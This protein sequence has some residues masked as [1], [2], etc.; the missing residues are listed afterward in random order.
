MVGHGLHE[1]CM[2]TSVCFIG[3]KDGFNQT[4]RCSQNFKPSN[5]LGF[6]FKS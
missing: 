5:E 3:Q 2:T 1:T 4:F 6:C